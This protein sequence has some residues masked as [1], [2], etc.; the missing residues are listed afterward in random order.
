M[1]V[2]LSFGYGMKTWT[3]AQLEAET[4]IAIRPGEDEAEYF[5][6]FMEHWS[7]AGVQEPMSIYTEYD[8][9]NWFPRSRDGMDMTASMAGSG[10]HVSSV[11]LSSFAYSDSFR[12]T[13]FL[14]VQRT[15]DAHADHETATPLTERGGPLAKNIRQYKPKFFNSL[16][17]LWN[18]MDTAKG[19]QRFTPEAIEHLG[20]PESLDPYD[21]IPFLDFL[22][23]ADNI[24]VLGP[25]A[26]DRLNRSLDWMEHEASM[27]KGR[28]VTAMEVL[29]EACP[30]LAQSSYTLESVSEIFENLR[31]IRGHEGA[32][33]SL[34]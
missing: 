33:I 30:S 26:V 6:Y 17:E 29:V 14:S 5:E 2:T 19:D 11:D 25:M 12:D 27:A 15:F 13:L 16:R 10:E 31:E 24:G 28:P 22:N 18:S 8:G 4:G 1:S 3:A 34:G 20:V 23:F 7:K 9:R 32:Y 21:L